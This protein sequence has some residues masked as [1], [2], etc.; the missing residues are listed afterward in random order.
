M[1]ND[2][3]A[4]HA[5]GSDRIR[6]GLIGAGGRGR[7]AAKD[8]VGAA[9]GVEIVAIAEMFPDK[10][11]EA[12][13]VLA[14]SLG[15][16]FTAKDDSCFL[17]FDAYRNVIDSDVDLVLLA[18]P[19]GFRPAHIEY[20][21]AKGKHIFAEKPVAAYAVG[22]RSI[23][24]SA[25]RIDEKKLSFICGT[26]RRH[27]PSY[28][29]CIDRIHG[30]DIGEI[31]SGQATWCQG[32]VRMFPRKPEWSD[33]EWHIR[34]WWY[35]TW[36]SGDHNVEQHIHNVDIL[37]WAL[38]GPPIS[39]YGTGG[40]EVRTD[41]VY[42]HVFDHV[43]VEFVYANG[44]RVTSMSRQIDGTQPRIGEWIVGT[45][46]QCRPNKGVIEGEKKFR[47]DGDQKMSVGMHR[48]HVD[49]I[50]SIRGSIDRINEAQRIAETTLTMIMGRMSAY[51]G[52]ELTWEQALNSK[53]DSTPKRLDFAASYPTPPVPTPGKT[54]FI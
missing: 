5:G 53:E 30:G 48:E 9:D 38:G 34:N 1:V 15:D 11:D 46:G 54:P 41:P 32:G 35:F 28:I 36:L 25:K 51:T 43:T 42:G 3:P 23:M 47:Y 6:V 22:C 45:K 40:R 31:V 33:L 29:E 18:T 12:K 21:V 14:E 24:E 13:K 39:A 44:A 16:K 52:K 50:N 4:V 2:I 10:L 26:Q 19:P 49:L 8:C 7:G 17:G 37:N 20:A 27:M